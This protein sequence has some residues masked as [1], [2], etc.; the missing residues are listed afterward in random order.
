MGRGKC[1]WDNLVTCYTIPY[2]ADKIKLSLLWKT[3][4]NFNLM[5][6]NKTES[7]Y[8]RAVSLFN[9]LSDFAVKYNSSFTNKMIIQPYK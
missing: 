9:Y 4:M 6:C 7:K 1:L 2:S 5:P 8:S 3:Q